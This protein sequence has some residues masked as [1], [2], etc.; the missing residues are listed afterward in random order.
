MALQAV[1][2]ELRSS[3]LKRE[4]PPAGAGRGARGRAGRSNYTVISG[5]RAGC[6]ARRGGRRAGPPAGAA[7]LREPPQS[8]ESCRRANT[9]MSLRA[10]TTGDVRWPPPLPQ[11]SAIHAQFSRTKAPVE[12]SRAFEP[13]R[14]RPP[15]T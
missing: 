3:A 7:R 11:C 12:G 5:R 13:A 4:P 15:W 2:S 1:G 14:R 10:P 9:R 6:G 8:A